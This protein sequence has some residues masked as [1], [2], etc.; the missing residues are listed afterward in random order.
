MGWSCAAKASLV[1]RAITAE[2]KKAY[3]TVETS[4]GLPDGGFWEI[5]RKEHADGA[6]TGTVWKAV[7]A[8]HVIKSGSFKIS[9]EGKIVRFP[10][11]PAAIKAAAEKAG[12][13]EYA[14][15]YGG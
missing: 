5:S 15:V 11:L 12:A 6:I 2:I 3:P 13:D 4:N 1:E 8:D 10:R 7:D 14:R 9:P